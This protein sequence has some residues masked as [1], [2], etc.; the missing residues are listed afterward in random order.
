MRVG[1]EGMHFNKVFYRS[2]NFWGGVVALILSGWGFSPVTGTSVYEVV[3]SA[4]L[5]V[6]GVIELVRGCSGTPRTR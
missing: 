6:I 4:I 3:M 2:S 5:A 1:D